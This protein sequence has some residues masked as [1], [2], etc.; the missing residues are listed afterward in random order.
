DVLVDLTLQLAQLRFDVV[1]R[2]LLVGDRREFCRGRLVRAHRS[3]LLFAPVRRLP[4]ASQ[5]IPAAPSS[6][7]TT[8]AYRAHDQFF[9]NVEP[10]SVWRVRS[11]PTPRNIAPK[12]RSSAPPMPNPRYRRRF[13]SGSTVSCL[14]YATTRSRSSASVCCG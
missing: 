3:V 6:V 9:V 2:D 10:V 8:I 7:T 12:Q 1:T 5:V 4:R 14:K 13:L 11:S